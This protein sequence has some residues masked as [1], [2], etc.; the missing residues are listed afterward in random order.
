MRILVINGSSDLYGANRI[1]AE[2]L[3]ILA[4]KNQL[5]L[6]LPSTGPFNSYIQELIPTIEVIVLERL[7]TVSRK[8]FTLTGIFTSLR[9]YLSSYRSLKNIIKQHH[10]ELAYINTLAC[11]LCLRMCRSLKLK[12]VTH[13]HEIIESPKIAAILINKLSLRWADRVIAVSNAVKDNLAVFVPEKTVNEKVTVIRNGI[14]SVSPNLA[15]QHDAKIK[16]TLIGRIKPEKGIWFFLD[17]INLLDQ[18]TAAKCHFY[19]IGGAAPGGDHFVEK[20]Q[21]D[22]ATHIYQPHISYVAFIPD[23]TSWQQESDI[24]VVPSIMKDPFPTTVLEAMRVAKPVIATNNG[25]AAEAIV[26]KVTGYLI[27]SGNVTSFANNLTAL[28]NDQNLRQQ[29]GQNGLKRFE[30]HFLKIHYQRKINSFFGDHVV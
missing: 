18:Q 13:V 23:V 30:E 20:L 15:V 26:D 1:L 7:P 22:I 17:A 11:F 16:I 4:V 6:V 21:Q 3:E 29:M 9:N 10:I 8:M 2:T 28:I 12:S 25:G 19:I 27:S 24:L 5:V 14:P